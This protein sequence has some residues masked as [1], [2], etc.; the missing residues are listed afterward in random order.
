MYTHLKKFF[1]TNSVFQQL[2][3]YPLE[4]ASFSARAYLSPWAN[5]V[6]N[7]WLH[8]P[9]PHTHRCY[10]ATRGQRTAL[11]EPGSEGPCMFSWEF[12]LRHC[13]FMLINSDLSLMEGILLKG[14]DVQGLPLWLIF[15]CCLFHWVFIV[16]IGQGRKPST[17]DMKHGTYFENIY[18][19]DS[20]IFV[21]KTQWYLK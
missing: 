15:T 12:S 21:F 16:R 7:T 14:C 4:R 3:L 6:C 19:W 8:L 2:C 17:Q 1:A 20:N 18:S 9:P 13:A 10:C 5:G 11:T